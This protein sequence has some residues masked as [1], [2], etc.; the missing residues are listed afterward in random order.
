[1]TREWLT[2]YDEQKRRLGASQPQLRA[3]TLPPRQLHHYPHPYPHPYPHS[4]NDFYRRDYRSHE[5]EETYED[6]EFGEPRPEDE[7]DGEPEEET[8]SKE[9]GTE[10]EGEEVE[11]MYPRARAA[12]SGRRRSS[13]TRDT[14]RGRGAPQG[15]QEASGV[16]R[17][18][19]VVVRT[20]AYE[21]VRGEL[22]HPMHARMHTVA[23]PFPL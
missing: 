4:R 2:L 21:T 12:A 13:T 9:E 7:Y 18:E 11:Q 20:Y 8:R 14:E 17:E 6:E 15:R 22:L 3:H 10:E 23:F 16:E 5:S 1:M 19:K